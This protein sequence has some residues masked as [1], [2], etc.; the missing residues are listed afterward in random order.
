MRKNKIRKST[1]IPLAFTLYSIV[2]YAYL[3]PR[4]TASTGSIIFAIVLNALI[5]LA[6]WWLYR[7]KE[8][9]ALEREREMMEQIRKNQDLT[10]NNH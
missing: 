1:W 3:L 2:I 9:M 6:L 7:K 4:S 10:S 5:I 8:K